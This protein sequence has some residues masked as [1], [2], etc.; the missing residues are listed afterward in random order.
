MVPRSPAHLH[1]GNGWSAIERLSFRGPSSRLLP[2][3]AL[4]LKNLMNDIDLF[5]LTRAL[6]DF[7]STTKS[8][9]QVGDFLARPS[10]RIGLSFFRSFRAH[11][12]RARPRQSPSHLRLSRRHPFHS[13]RHGSSLFRF[14]RRSHLHLGT[15]FVRCQGYC[16]SHDRGRRIAA[17]LRYPQ[18][19]SALCRW[20][21]T[22]QHRRQNHGCIA[23]RFTLSHQR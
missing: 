4:P 14:A 13:H 18:S 17:R 20:R 10:R 2:F 16:R 15:R 9:R 8:E 3:L 7:D 11:P 5:S 12:V 22:R 19:G 6:V 23:S 1:N 21:R